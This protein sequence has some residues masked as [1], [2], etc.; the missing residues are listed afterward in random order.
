M[1]MEEVGFLGEGGTSRR[2]DFVIGLGWA[3]SYALRELNLSNIQLNDKAGGKLLS[4]LSVGLGK[5]KDIQARMDQIRA[6]VERT[7]LKSAPAKQFGWQ[8]IKFDTV[9]EPSSI[10]TEFA[11]CF[12]TWDFITC[13]VFS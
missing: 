3:G 2:V 5:K 4:A 8:A 1:E 9:I 12:R 6:E 13:C 10:F 11:M 7:S